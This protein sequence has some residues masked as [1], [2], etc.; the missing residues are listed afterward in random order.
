VQ[1]GRAGVVGSCRLLLLLRHAMQPGGVPQVPLSEHQALGL[2]RCTALYALPYAC[3][4]DL[5]IEHP[6]AVLQAVPWL[7]EGVVQSLSMPVGLETL[8]RVCS[9]AEEQS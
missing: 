7:F 5:Q 9:T 3:C 1:K 8:L 2:P 6:L 4:P